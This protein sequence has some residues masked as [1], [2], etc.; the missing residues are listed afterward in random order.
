MPTHEAEILRCARTIATLQ[1]RA[2]KLR[3]E[4]RVIKNNLKL[5]RKH[6]R[7]L[8]AMQA[9][10]DPDIVPIREFGIGMGYGRGR[11]PSKTRT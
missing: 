10:A 3:R 1:Q 6:M 8:I 9:T 11:A 4:L 5:E 7:A 2:R